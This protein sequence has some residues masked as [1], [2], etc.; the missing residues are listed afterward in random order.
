[1]TLHDS[2]NPMLQGIAT[3]L[4][5]VAGFLA[6]VLFTVVCLVLAELI[7]ERDGLIRAYGVR[8]GSLDSKEPGTQR[9]STWLRR[10]FQNGTTSR[11][12]ALYG[13]FPRRVG[14]LPDRRDMQLKLN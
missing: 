13:F 14:G 12:P 6:L 2:F 11:G 5:F 9:Q 4:I 10:A 3:L 1:M 7:S 8:S